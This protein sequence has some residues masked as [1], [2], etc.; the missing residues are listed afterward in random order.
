[1]S[2]YGHNSHAFEDWYRGASD[3]YWCTYHECEHHNE[4]ECE[5]ISEFANGLSD[6]LVSDDAVDMNVWLATHTVET[7]A[8]ESQV[9]E[10]K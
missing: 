7:H 8:V 1:M 6:I 10:D 5:E 4:T 3:S 2:L 9:V